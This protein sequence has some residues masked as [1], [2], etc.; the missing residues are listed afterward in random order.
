MNNNKI[1]R[2]LSIG[3]IICFM[4]VFINLVSADLATNLVSYWKFDET[5]GSTAYDN[6]ASNDGSINNL[7]IDETGKINTAFEWADRTAA[8]YVSIPS[9]S[10]LNYTNNTFTYSLW[11]YPTENPS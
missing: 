10:S 1:L 9:D 4:F 8:R 6:V 11:V 7:S 2:V 3:F 5:T